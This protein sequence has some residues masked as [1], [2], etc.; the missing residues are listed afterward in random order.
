M[1]YKGRGP[2]QLTGRANYRSAGT[3]LSLPLESDPEKVAFPS[4]GFKAAAWYWKNH[5]SGNLNRYCDSGSLTDFRS[6]T[7][8]IN[9][10]Q[11]GAADRETRWATAKTK[12]GCA[13]IA[14]RNV[15]AVPPHFPKEKQAEPEVAFTVAL[16]SDEKT[17][18]LS[19]SGFEGSEPFSFE[20]YIAGEKVAGYDSESSVLLL[21]NERLQEFGKLIFTGAEYWVNVTNAAGT[22]KIDGLSVKSLMEKYDD[23]GESAGTKDQ[24]WIQVIGG[25]VGAC[26]FVGVGGYVAAWAWSKKKGRGKENAIE[27]KPRAAS[28]AV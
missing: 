5:W 13:A 21:T 20:W 2:I 22:L 6:L 23:N 19:V 25:V 17:K 8:K 27:L 1:R 11:N 18:L 24:Q 12:L 10:G 16:S 3:S 4:G 7:Q 26:A 15:G 14:P 28:Q 9:G